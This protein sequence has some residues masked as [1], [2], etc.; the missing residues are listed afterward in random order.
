MYVL[1]LA[2][3]FL[4]VGHCFP[5]RAHF[6]LRNPRKMVGTNSNFLPSP[7][8]LPFTHLPVILSF[9]L[10]FPCSLFFSNMVDLLLCTWYY[11]AECLEFKGEKTWV[12]QR[13]IQGETKDRK[14]HWR[15]FSV[16]RQRGNQ[17]V[18]NR[19]SGRTQKRRALN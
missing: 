15:T 12:F 13:T 17:V 18:G 2:D 5:F 1:C 8:F 11:N 6:W 10:S 4:N 14:P 16:A 19:V 9:S 3:F 7:F